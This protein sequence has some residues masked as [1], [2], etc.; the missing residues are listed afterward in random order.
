MIL[1]CMYKTGAILGVAMALDTQ[2]AH[3]PSHWKPDIRCWIVEL[4]QWEPRRQE[5]KE[6][7]QKDCPAHFLFLTQT[8]ITF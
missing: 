2:A 5:T 1:F 7:W 4:S 3:L 8:Q 6:K